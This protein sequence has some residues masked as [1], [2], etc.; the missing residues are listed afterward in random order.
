[1]LIGWTAHVYCFL[2]LFNPIAMAL[3]ILLLFYHI[4]LLLTHPAVLALNYLLL[5]PHFHEVLDNNVKRLTGDGVILWIIFAELW[6][7]FI[8]LI[9]Y[10]ISRYFN[11]PIFPEFLKREIA[12]QCFYIPL[13]LPTLNL[14][15]DR[16][17][18]NVLQQFMIIIWSSYSVLSILIHVGMEMFIAKSKR[19]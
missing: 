7:F 14:L 10:K 19:N 2:F 15:L 11:G 8:T 18:K 16:Q 6:C 17:H 13:S 12:M 1:M 9:Y 5:Y 3:L 4:L